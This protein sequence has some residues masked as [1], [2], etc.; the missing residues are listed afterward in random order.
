M[1]NFCYYCTKEESDTLMKSP[2]N[3]KK[4]Y[5]HKNCYYI[6]RQQRSECF[7]CKC[8]FP[9]LEYE[10]SIE[11]LAT[12]YRFKKVNATIHRHEFTVNRSMEKHGTER[13]YNDI[14]GKL[15][16]RNEW[17]NGMKII[18]DEGIARR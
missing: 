10:W 14:T 3:C 5:I 12:I 16:I 7:C 4:Q 15:L 9:P 18:S 8:D 2:C 11:G 6:I 1:D 13:I 17:M